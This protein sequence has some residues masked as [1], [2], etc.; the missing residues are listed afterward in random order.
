MNS[1]TRLLLIRHAEVE[2]RYQR[3]FGG[4]IDMDI[5]PRGHAQ[6][7]ALAD[8]LR[9]RTLDA[10]YASPMKRVQ[11]TLAPLLNNGAPRPEIMPDL[12]EVDFGDWTGLNYEQVLEKFGVGA[13]A[14]L[15]QLE[16]GA[17]PS[18]ETGATC[19]ARIEP[20]LRQIVAAHVGKTVA[21]YC[22]G[23]VTRMMLST[24]LDLPWPKTDAFQIDYASVT[25]VAIGS[26]R[27]RIEL[28]NFAPWRYQLSPTL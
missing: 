20:C 12:R 10:I 5:S 25:E 11:Q 2:V 19:R 18:A 13:N 23:G 28:L 7:S 14:W 24:L 16:C 9:H 22:H 17:I 26:D 8:F 3:V 21:I 6:A 4:R 1:P 27:A 15:D